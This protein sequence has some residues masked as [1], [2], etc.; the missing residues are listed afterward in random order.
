MVLNRIQKWSRKERDGRRAKRTTYTRG[1]KWSTGNC[2]TSGIEAKFI[3]RRLRETYTALI[4]ASLSYYY[5]YYIMCK[6]RTRHPQLRLRDL[7]K[8]EHPLYYTTYHV[9]CHH[10]VIAIRA[11]S[12]LSL[13]VNLA[14]GKLNDFAVFSL[15][16][17]HFYTFS[18]RDHLYIMYTVHAY[19]W[20]PCLLPHSCKWLSNAPGPKIWFRVKGKEVRFF[21]RRVQ[22]NANCV[23]V[24]QKKKMK[25]VR[26]R[27][28]DF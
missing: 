21:L 15:F 23:I 1:E 4:Y 10:V 19:D 2:R 8:R 11:R 17:N 9:I 26:N 3:N 27:L 20:K 6:Y 22:I 24:I 28:V 14:K 13:Y 16:S 12:D 25:S 18:T 5:Y 7:W